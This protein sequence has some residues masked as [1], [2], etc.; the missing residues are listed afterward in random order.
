MS[1]GI[2]GLSRFRVNLYM[3]R[4]SVVAAIRSI[5]YEILSFEELGLPKCVRELADKP[6]GLVL[7]CGPTGCGKSTTLAALVNKI[8]NERRCHVVTIE[9]PI[10]YLHTHKLSI[11]NQREVFADTHSFAA[12]LKHILRQDPDVIMI[13]EMRDLETIMVALT[14]AE[15]G[16]LVFATLHS[17]DATQSITRMVDVFPPHQQLQVRTQ[18]S[19][20][21]E[22][23]LVQKLLPRKNAN[24]RVLALEIMMAT[25]AIRSLIREDKLHQIYSAI[26]TGGGLGMQTMNMALYRLYKGGQITY[27]EALDNSMNQEELLRLMGKGF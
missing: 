25:P 18:L 13:G 15:T 7:V 17:N 23:V 27:D 22:G 3:D 5:P 14:V 19:F 8:N 24:G 6:Q 20:V 10:E 16:H 4:G 11:I 9:D 2:K 21:L 26:S 1:F 12:A